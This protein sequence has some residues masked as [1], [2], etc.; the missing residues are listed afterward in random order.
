VRSSTSN[1]RSRSSSSIRTLWP[2]LWIPALLLIALGIGAWEVY[3]R[4]HGFMPSLGDDAMLWAISRQQASDSTPAPVLVG[5]SRMQMDIDRERFSAATGWEPAVQ[6]AIVRGP[7]LPILRSFA[8]DPDFR[9]EI[10]CEVNPSLFFAQTPNL[11]REVEDYMATFE[12]R[13]I[14][15]RVEQRIGMIVQGNLVTRLPDLRPGIIFKAIHF[16]Q[17]PQP[18]Y[19]GGIGADRFRYADYKLVPNPSAMRKRIRKALSLSDPRPLESA[20]FEQLLQDVE[21]MV[22][23][24]RVRGGRV[25]FI[26]LPSAG[27]VLARERRWWDRRQWWDVFAAQTRAATIHFQDYPLLAVFAPPDGDH[28]GRRGAMHFSERLGHVLTKRRIA[29]GP[30]RQP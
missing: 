28:L 18:G 24:L 30:K 3:W 4:G 19:M 21:G 7:S 16:R 6:L 11:D 14:F 15:D 26:R 13:T 27:D 9:G 23:A 5:S 1:S 20:E 2:R 22:E 12:N 8:F 17:M 10:L 29:P 25:T